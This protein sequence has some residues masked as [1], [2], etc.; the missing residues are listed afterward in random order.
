[1]RTRVLVH[2]EHTGVPDEPLWSC[3]FWQAFESR[4]VIYFGQLAFVGSELQHRCR[5][6]QYTPPNFLNLPYCSLP[7]YLVHPNLQL[8]TLPGRHHRILGSLCLDVVGGLC[9][10]TVLQLNP[11]EA[12]K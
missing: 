5:D 9:G 10:Q 12:S 2:L 11:A 6:F 3:V 7:D 8:P 4:V 1:M